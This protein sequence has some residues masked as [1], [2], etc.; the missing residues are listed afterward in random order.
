MKLRFF[1]LW[2]LAVLTFYGCE[3]NAI[4]SPK[5]SRFIA[6][7]HILKI[8]EKENL[9]RGVK[10]FLHEEQNL[11]NKEIW[12]QEA[13]HSN[14][15][16]SYIPEN[17]PKFS[18]PYYLIP[19]EDAHFFFTD[20]LDPRVADQL[21][22]KISGKKHFKLFVHPESEVY[23]D[24]LKRSYNYIS[25][26][27]T[28]FFAS[29][30]SSYRSLIVWNRNNGERKPFIAKI[31]LDKNLV[32]NIDRLVSENE[33]ERSIANQK[34][35]D[36]IGDKKLNSM[37]LKLFP[38][39]A[40][41]IIDKSH[42]GAPEKSGGQ[43]I[44]EIPDEVFRSEK[45]WFSILVLMSPH[46]TSAPFIMDVIKQSGLSSYDFVKTYMIDSYLDMFEEISLK[47]GINFEPNLQNLVF[48]T[49]ND[50]KPTG[51]WILRDVGGV[52][53]DIFNMAKKKELIDVYMEKASAVKYKLQGKRAS[54]INSY[55][56]FYKRQIFDMMVNELA[57]R[58]PTLTTEQVQTL[59][60]T[61][62]SKYTKMIN[63][64]LGLNLKSAPN[65]VDYK[66]IEEMVIAQ[67]GLDEKISKKEIK[68]TDNLK[69]FIEN[70]KIRNEWIELSPQ[71]GKSE[72]YL[73]NHGLYQISNK[74]I[75]GIALFNRDEQEE[76]NAN[77]KML[78]NFKML[79]IEA[80]DKTS[81]LGMMSS[82]FTRMI[83]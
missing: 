4:L 22:M 3:R 63:T 80:P 26:E 18:L 56:F 64:H 72:F 28:E 6:S 41:L 47:N 29:P 68:D 14:R 54:Y 40:G 35:F 17:N 53:P 39:T 44:R 25:H 11:H 67:T 5:V 34:V 49:T 57:K 62:D 60:N 9:A 66:R 81:C 27:Q 2:F 71:K 42:S 12:G 32:D 30:T 76:Y 75:V 65:L 50:L 82:F 1:L 36:L 21:V 24:F 37:N 15:N 43:L 77:D 33:I 59:K 83:K 78:I 46:S 48:E 73:T 16:P 52:L 70:K 45:K 8:E 69:T 38:E 55:V 74:K 58:D 79:T 23:Y 20:S 51:K 10:E 19:E 13:S 31:S 7:E 61:I